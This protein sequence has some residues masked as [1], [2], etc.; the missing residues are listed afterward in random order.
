MDLADEILRDG[1]ES[2][3]ILCGAGISLP[4]PTSLPTVARF[5]SELL[6]E[7]GA[8]PEVTEEVLQRSRRTPAPR[9]EAL[10]EEIAKSGD[11]DFDVG[12]IFDT[13]TFNA[14]HSAIAALLRA[15]GAA[16]TTNF[17]NAI[18]LAGGGRARVVFTGSDLA[19]L[20]APDGLLCKPHGTNALGG[21]PRSL[22]VMSV[23][24]LSRTNRGFALL[25]NLRR[26]LC[27][28][29]DDRTVVVLGY[30]GSDDFD[31]T[32]LLLSSHPRHLLWF[33][34]APSPEEPVEV[35]AEELQ[36]NVKAFVALPLR[37]FSGRIDGVLRRVA[38]R[39]GVEP[40]S[41]P[42]A[43]PY[44]VADYI[45][46][47]FDSP[48]RRRELLDT[49][50][51]QYALYEEVLTGEAFLS[52][53]VAVQRLKA[54]FR[55]GRHAEVEREAGMLPP[56]LS[57]DHRFPAL[58]FRAA[59]L[60]ATS[61]FDEATGAMAELVDLCGDDDVGRMNALNQ[62]GG[63][64]LQARQPE[65]AANAFQ[66][67]LDLQSKSANLA[68][69]AASLWGLGA[70]EGIRGQLDRSLE[71]FRQAREV[72]VAL[73]DES[74]LAW[75]DYNCADCCMNLGRLDEARAYL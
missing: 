60:A 43:T 70:V 58:Y 67:A 55:L 6:A 4:P 7:C 31:V 14:T 34:W 39:L 48:A 61:R 30:S 72:Y 52:P 54:L 41:G 28:L 12:R 68:T 51:L 5:L 49:V 38:Q 73:G 50:L 15:D 40:A 53:G 18:E 10:I 71:L 59:S 25:P 36:P 13:T 57:L 35:A 75:S 37:C 17:D 1:A 69:E 65:E 24:A 21:E 27:S 46:A 29:L 47:H 26:L 2:V 42:P 33:D 64:H 56:E 66:E 16:I 3:T 32:P 11:R 20:P 9:F 8:S 63:I 45:A 74:N 22:L 44:T 62:M 23:A 19:R